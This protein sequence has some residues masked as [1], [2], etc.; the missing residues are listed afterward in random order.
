M[1]NKHETRFQ[2]FFSVY[3]E[4]NST[5][6]WV[7]I[8]HILFRYTNGRRI[9]VA[10]PYKNMKRLLPYGEPF[11]GKWKENII[12]LADVVMLLLMGQ[13]F[14][15]VFM[16]RYVIHNTETWPIYIIEANRVRYN[17]IPP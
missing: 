8:F 9:F 16:S 7:K 13:A 6:R 5:F 3:S 2:F 15:N 11:S 1:D 14:N 17:V 12:L 4:K 10:N